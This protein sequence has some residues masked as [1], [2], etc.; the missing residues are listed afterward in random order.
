MS[1]E[2]GKLGGKKRSTKSESVEEAGGIPGS[3]HGPTLQ[4]WRGVGESWRRE[5]RVRDVGTPHAD[6]AGEHSLLLLATSKG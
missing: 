2:L 1:G 3:A 4:H 5:K 6:A